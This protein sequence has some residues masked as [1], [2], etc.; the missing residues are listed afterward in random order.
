L[1]WCSDRKKIDIFVGLRL[2]RRYS[3]QIW[4]IATRAGVLRAAY[5]P[6]AD[7]QI[8]AALA[9]ELA[10]ERQSFGHTLQNLK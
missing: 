6:D 5:L 3:H 1:A 10:E 2:L 7:I 8:I 9:D 4:R